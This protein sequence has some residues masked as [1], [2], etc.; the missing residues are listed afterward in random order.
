LL[1]STKAVCHSKSFP[2]GTRRRSYNANYRGEK[3]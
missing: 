2:G 3:K 1:T